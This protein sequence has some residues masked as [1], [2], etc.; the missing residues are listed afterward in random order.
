METAH[1]SPPATD[2]A[3]VA[4]D[5]PVYA[6]STV[7]RWGRAILAAFARRARAA[8]DYEALAQMSERELADIGLS[9][10]YV[11]DVAAGAGSRL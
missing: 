3:C 2:P 5:L 6:A 7:A 1:T 8:R 4:A 10:G 11:S 9:R